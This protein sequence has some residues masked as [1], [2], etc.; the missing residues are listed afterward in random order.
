MRNEYIGNREPLFNGGLRSALEVYGVQF[1]FLFDGRV[2]GDIFN[3]TGQN[4]MSN[5]QSASLE[6]YRG[7]QVVVDGVVDDGNGGYVQNNKPITLT[8]TTINSYFTI[9]D[10]NF[11]EDGSYLRLS[12]IT[13]GYDFARLMKNQKVVKGLNVSF[14]ANNLF[15]LTKYTGTDPMCNAST[16]SGG[17][18]S[19]GID[20]WPIPSIR[21]YNFSLNVKF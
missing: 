1:G 5:G 8:P 21:S 16:S 15:M 13:L 14:T 2:G 9:V 11:I 6:N 4:L 3:Y 7:R 12:Y 17:T 18:G 20:Y 10:E 19:A